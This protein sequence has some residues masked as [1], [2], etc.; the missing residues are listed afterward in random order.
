LGV[1][2]AMPLLLAALV[3]GG[4]GGGDIKLMAASGIVLGFIGSIAAMVIGLTCISLSDW[5]IREHT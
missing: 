2:A 3:W 1:L 5:K 4:L